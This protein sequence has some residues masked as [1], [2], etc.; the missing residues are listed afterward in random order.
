MKFYYFLFLV[1]VLILT[2]TLVA[3]DPGTDH[4]K[5]L[6]NFEDGTLD[7]KIGNAHGDYHGDNIV[8]EDGDLVNYPNPD[9]QSA[10]SWVTLPGDVID[11]ASY[12]EVAIAAWF[13]P[14][15]MYNTQ[16]NT[17][18]FFGNDGDGAGT[19]SD[20]MAL[21][22]RRADNHARFWFTAGNPAGYMAEDGVNDDAY[23]NYNYDE[24]YHVVCQVN[25]MS[26]MMMYHDGVWVGTTPLSINPLTGGIKGIEDISPNFAMFCHSTYAGDTP[27][28]GSLHEIMIFDKALTDEEVAFL[29]N[30]GVNGYPPVDGV[31]NK[32]AQLPEVFSLSQNHPNPF[33]PTTN[34]AF[35]LKQKEAVKLTVYDVLGKQVA[36][37]LDETRNPGEHTISF[38]AEGLNSGVYY[39]RLQTKG[40]AVTKKMVLM[41]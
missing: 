6:W 13:T 29:F 2:G 23:G 35:T 3:Q 27:W 22:P 33:N 10:D 36:T 37:L 1:L 5:H 18:W 38:D 34:I 31:E 15:G 17:L 40:Q 30:A 21:Q 26:E 16:W 7:D 28:V 12:N 19:G 9:T 14:D 8:V 24:L 20:G 25:D 39:Y 4:L 11:L 32:N 41:R